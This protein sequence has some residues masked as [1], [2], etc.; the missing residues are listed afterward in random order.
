MNRRVFFVFICFFCVFS[1]LSDICSASTHPSGDWPVRDEI[2]QL[3]SNS[4]F[5]LRRICTDLKRDTG[6]ELVVLL[7]RT[8]YGQDPQQY[9]VKLFNDWGIGRAGIDD[10]ILL[11][12]AM[13]DR[14]GEIIPGKRYKSLLNGSV[15]SDLIKQQA[16]PSIKAGR[17]NEGIIRAATEIARQIRDYER[18]HQGY[19]RPTNAEK[20]LTTSANRSNPTSVPRTT[21]PANVTR[22]QSPSSAPPSPLPS[23]LFSS[24][25]RPIIR[26]VYFV[27]VIIWTAAIFFFFFTAFTS[28]VLIFPKTA[29]I[30]LFGVSGAALAFFGYHLL[31]LNDGLLDQLTA[32][33]GGTGL[34]ALL[35]CSSHVCPRCNKWMSVTRRTLVSATYSSSG[36]GECTEH[37]EHCRYHNVYIY[38]IPRRTRSRSS[39]SHRSGGGRS[40]GGG[41]GA[42]W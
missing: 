38:T 5:S 13:N 41:G 17:P 24:P 14:R 7:T 21:K 25:M 2:R 28:G 32:G 33:S 9:G 34:L 6:A 30:L 35:F 12:F 40:S 15:C 18:V 19:G 36:R 20:P 23:R 10:G 37:C 22:Q 3:D 31:N 11:M 4:L 16:I 27:S 1:C 8:T 26:I 39:S 42:G 29:A